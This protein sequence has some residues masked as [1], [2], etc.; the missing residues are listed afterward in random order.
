MAE[1]RPVLP[2]PVGPMKTMFSALG[3]KSSSARVLTCLLTGVILRSH[4][5]QEEFL[6]GDLLVLGVP[7]LLLEQVEDLLEVEVFEQLLELFSHGVLRVG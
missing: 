5:T 1:A 2:T 6:V 4:E 3:M 7:S